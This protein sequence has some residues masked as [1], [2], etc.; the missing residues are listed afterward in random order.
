MLCSLPKLK[1]KTL[2]ILI[3]LLPALNYLEASISMHKPLP[4]AQSLIG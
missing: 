1:M 2:R 4:L 3:Q